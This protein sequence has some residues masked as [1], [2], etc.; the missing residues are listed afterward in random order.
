VVNSMASERDHLFISYAGEDGLFVDWLC[1]K[2]ASEGYRVWCDRLKLLG[3]ESYPRDIDQAIKD[4]TFRLIA[5]LSK[6]SLR[7]PNPLK[8]RTL[9]LNLGRGRGEDF[10]IPLNL[11][12][13]TPSE[14][15]WMQSDLTY[16]PFYRS[17]A[18]GLR[19]LFKKLETINAPKTPDVRASLV[20]FLNSSEAVRPQ[21]ERIWSNIVE[22]IELPGIIFRYEQ[23][24]LMS[25][26]EAAA[27]LRVW[28][29]FRENA[30][31]CWSFQHPPADLDLKYQFNLRGRLEDWVS[32][33]SPDLNPRNI[34]KKVLNASLRHLSLARGLVEDSSSGIL[35]FPPGIVA[36]DRLQFDGYCGGS[37][38]LSGG[39]K[40]FKTVR[41]DEV[42]RYHLAPVLRFWLDFYGKSV[43]NVKIRLYL[44]DSQGN[45]LEAR[46]ALRRRKAVTKGWWN[47][48]WASRV[49][50]ILHFLACGR[51]RIELAQEPGQRFVIE[52]FPLRMTSPCALDEAALTSPDDAK[53]EA[54][55]FER[56]ST[57]ENDEE[58]EADSEKE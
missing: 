35:Y 41:G 1:R 47:Y 48:E 27:A 12:G 49:L 31:L 55:W 8:E 43:V 2:L 7:K 25:P 37:W 36:G 38:V 17:W 3:G 29:H 16:V 26:A 40:T 13:L 22:V 52:K 50:A 14:L 15:D 6:S 10:L 9:A 45:P 33:T 58:E 51:A 56:D 32:A 11:D 30:T 19:Q 54:A 24:R 18:E 57:R 44:T 5:V 53:E 46:S 28:P 20:S 34:G 42:V 4:R 23:D 21:T 39:H